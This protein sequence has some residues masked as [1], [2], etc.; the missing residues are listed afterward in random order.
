MRISQLDITPI[1]S[2]FQITLNSRGRRANRLFSL[3]LFHLLSPKVPVVQKPG[4]LYRLG[5][6]V[7]RMAGEQQ[8]VPRL[9]SPRCRYFIRVRTRAR[10]RQTRSGGTDRNA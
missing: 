2:S 9:Y 7:C 4:A 8:I 1:P 6:R 3:L 10:S 5:G